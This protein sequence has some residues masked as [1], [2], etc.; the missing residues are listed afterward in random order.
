MLPEDDKD[1]DM[2]ET[3]KGAPARQL[4]PDASPGADDESEE[5]SQKGDG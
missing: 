2:I 5:D 3:V 1:E 4:A